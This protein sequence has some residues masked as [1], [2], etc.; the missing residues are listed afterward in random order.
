MRRWSEKSQEWKTT[1]IPSI[2]FT[3]SEGVLGC[4]DVHVIMDGLET[5]L[6]TDDLHLFSESF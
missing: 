1:V 3:T 4:I 2:A 5:T 6:R